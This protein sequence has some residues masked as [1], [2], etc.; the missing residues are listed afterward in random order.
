MFIQKK[1]IECQI[2]QINKIHSK[3]LRSLEQKQQLT[4]EKERH[5]KAEAIKELES[6]RLENLDDELERLNT[7]PRIANSLN[8][9]DSRIRLNKMHKVAVGRSLELRE[10]LKDTHYIINHG[11]NFKLMIVNIIARKLKQM[12]E[13]QHYES[14]EPLRHDTAL[15]HIQEDR[16]TV[17]WYQKNIGGFIN[18]HGF[19]KELI[20]GDCVLESTTS[21]ESA[22]SFFVANSNVAMRDPGWMKKTYY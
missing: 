16:H 21:C 2:E 8:T 14:F 12:F 11:Q 3:F 4:L 5:P 22:I 10:Q 1:L 20:S 17:A 6:R 9:V 15:R 18:D 19:R 7:I 13:L